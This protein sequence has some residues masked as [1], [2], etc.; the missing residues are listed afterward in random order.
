MYP[1]DKSGDSYS[2]P[3][4]VVSIDANAF[5]YS[6]VRTVTVPDGV[7]S[8]G[9]GAFS[10]SS[11]TDVTLGSGITSISGYTFN[12]CSDLRS[13]NIPVGV[14]EIG[15]YAFARCTELTS[16][17]I[18]NTVTKI[19]DSAFYR[20][21]GLTSIVIPDSVTAMED[22]VF[23]DCSGLTSVT[24]GSGITE[25]P[26]RAFNG[27]SK[28]TS[29]VIPDN[30][31]E[32]SYSAFSECSNLATVSIGK[33]VT[34][35]YPY[36]FSDCPKLESFTV[37]DANT[38]YKSVDG[39]LFNKTGTTLINY[40]AAKTGTEYVIPDTVTELGDDAFMYSNLVSIT[41]GKNVSSLTVGAFY[42]CS[43]LESFTVADDNT[44]YSS[45]DGVLFNKDK[46]NLIIFPANKS[47]SLYNVP[48]TV[49]DIG[50]YAFR[51]C[52]RLV[53]VSIPDSV[54]DIDV[55]AFVGCKILEAINVSEQNADYCSVD[56][57]LFNKSKTNLM[58][59]PMKKP[60]TAFT[61]PNTVT[62]VDSRA[63]K[64]CTNIKTLTISDNLADIDGD[65][66][67][68]CKGLVTVNI[69]KNTKAIA[70]Y[71]FE[72]LWNLE[73]I[74]VSEQNA[75]YCSVDGVLF[76]KDKTAL[77]K[78]PEAKK[79]AS[80][81]VP[82]TVTSLKENAFAGN[83]VIESI[84]LP[85]GLKTIDG[86]SFYMTTKLTSFTVSGDNTVFASADGVLRYKDGGGLVWCP[87][88]WA[89]TL[90][91]DDGISKGVLNDDLALCNG[92]TCFQVK[93]GSSLYTVKGSVLYCGD[94]IV[95]YA[96]A[97]ESTSLSIAAS[98]SYVALPFIY[99]AENL[100]GITVDPKNMYFSSTEGSMYFEGGEELVVCPSGKTAF[101]FPAAVKSVYGMAF[102]G[103]KLTE[104]T[105]VKD[106]KISVGQMALYNCGSLNKIVIQEGADV[107]F[108]MDSILFDD[109][110][111]H[112]IYVVAPEGYTLDTSGFRSN[113]KIVYGE[114]PEPP[115]PSDE[116]GDG[117]V[118]GAVIG[119]A[120][121]VIAILGVA[122]FFMRKY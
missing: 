21:S 62:Y 103:D 9:H 6:K 67:D 84:T 64:D 76:N 119:T 111:E 37:A 80:Y 13:V 104:I 70:D 94:E 109:T 16:V 58:K 56:G 73:A 66:L 55:D 44:E 87:S 7:T 110:L 49:T 27:C 2:V 114:P 41:V 63:L 71:A 105:F 45:V 23:M 61:M 48:A 107:T 74:N 89:G 35:I 106:M 86:E 11:V 108:E 39:V 50:E 97:S 8:I 82:E 17:T 60:E 79:G 116:G 78:Y 5:R 99:D 18:P 65:L 113:V 1:A 112:T 85:A 83:W 25:I 53:S 95:G 34:D 115:T 120:V 10:D 101:V 72:R 47:A 20:C 92:I 93:E 96:S 52:D 14:T 91:V 26:Y 121:A 75:K 42:D 118:I 117:L 46:T 28:L 31:T 69:G 15:D 38:A 57:V 36:V 3:S 102:T 43:K 4:A 88:K 12:H 100:T 122:V 22:D 30:V 40:P 24:I 33:G 54:T 81:S 98:D 19:C 68:G 51:D 32:I 59:Y 90:V 77:I 29:A